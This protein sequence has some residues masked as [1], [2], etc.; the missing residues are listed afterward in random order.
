MCFLPSNLPHLNF[1]L[2]WEYP[3]VTI[4]AQGHNVV[5]VWKFKSQGFPA[6]QPTRE[7]TSLIPSNHPLGHFPI[8]LTTEPRNLGKPAVRWFPTT[9]LDREMHRLRAMCE[10][11]VRRG[12]KVLCHRHFGLQ[13]LKAMGWKEDRKQKSRFSKNDEVRT[14]LKNSES[15]VEDVGKVDKSKDLQKIH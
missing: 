13:E 8:M 3:A 1:L 9:A 6:K 2:L 10:E 14:H 15:Q 12:V 5:H 11:Q 7:F 4:G